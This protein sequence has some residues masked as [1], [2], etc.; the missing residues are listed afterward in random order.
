M[1]VWSRNY[2]HSPKE[3]NARIS[4]H[5]EKY[6]C[7]CKFSIDSSRHDCLEAVSIRQGKKSAYKLIEHRHLF[8]IINEITP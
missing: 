7:L 1:F 8:I 2:C 6:Y 5:V 3:I 4:L